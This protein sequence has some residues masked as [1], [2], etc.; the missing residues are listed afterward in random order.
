MSVSRRVPFNRARD[1][2]NRG[3]SFQPNTTSW[4]FSLLSTVSTVFFKQLGDN[5]VALASIGEQQD[6]FHFVVLD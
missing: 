6:D 3:K 2:R 1:V 5:G 4:H